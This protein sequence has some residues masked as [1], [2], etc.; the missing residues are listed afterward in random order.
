[1][2]NSE[3][4]K[5]SLFDIYHIEDKIHLWIKDEDGNARLFY[6]FYQ[7]I[8]YARGE[9]SVLKKLVHRFYQLDALAE[10]PVYTSKKLF[11]ENEK[12]EVLQLT[13]SRPSVLSRVS[14][15]L[16]ALYG[17]FD[18]YH[19]DI[20]VPTSYMVSKGLFPLCEL[21]LTYSEEKFGRRVRDVEVHNRIE[22]M[23]YSVP[24]LKTMY[25]SLSRSHR[26]DMKHNSIVL[27]CEDNFHEL[28]GKNPKELLQEIDRIFKTEDPDIVLSTFGDHTI[29]PYLFSQSQKLRI[30]PAFDRDKTAPI[31]RHVQTKGTSYNTYGTIVYR[32]PSYPLFGRWHIDSQNS[33]VHREADLLGIIELAR[34]SR[35]PIQK[36]SRASTGKALTSIE[37][38]VALRKGYLVPWQ[39]SAVESPKTALQLL[40]A[41]KGGLVFQPDISDGSVFEN[42]AQL[43]FAQMYPS[44]M[45][46]HNISPECVNCVC[47][48]KNRKAK[49]VPG[50]GYRICVRRRGIVSQALKHVLKRREYYKIGIK[51]RKETSKL[52]EYEQKQ[53]SLKWMLV[54][55]FGYLGYRNAKFG[56]L[57]SHESVNAFA[58]EKLLTAKECAE[59]RGYGFVHAITDSIF[60][61]KTDSSTFSREELNSLCEEIQSKTG[62]RIDVDGVYTWLLFPSSSQD[63]K[64]PVAN[65]YMGRFE[66]GKLKFRGIGSR[67][68][69]LPSIVKTAQNE[70]LEWMCGKVRV[71]ELKNSE[72]EILEIYNRYD[73]KLKKG[74]V[75]TEDLLV[76][77]S[78]SKTLEE[79]EVDGASSLSLLR[80]KELGI[81]VQA[82]EKIRYLVLNRK[83]KR[84]DRW[85]LPEEALQMMKKKER[86][87]A[88]PSVV[89][90]K[91]ETASEEIHWDRTYYR[92]LLV[93]SFREVWAPFASFSDFESLLDDQRWL[94]F[95]K[96]FTGALRS[97][98]GSGL[99]GI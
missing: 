99:A 87:S 89:P 40:E 42:V 9:E 48:E 8:V 73:L 27:R 35:L 47:C 58:R 31:R 83:G 3:I 74:T 7:P 96:E 82:G 88:K 86:T 50:L 92:K 43:D 49:I 33:F 20:E 55:S 17:K 2:N 84:K 41:D 81:D 94:P 19:S 72:T 46:N 14:R 67:R 22:D 4:V 60:I 59:E 64:M 80:L 66:N 45:V 39:K 23:E 93:A 62:I 52:G 57:E 21:K 97:Y 78:T 85:Y 54:T 63:H 1:M 69:D 30:F 90:K 32:A 37:V 51:E 76:R 10:I 56:R 75:E 36:M 24:K 98:Y 38:D 11:Y 44:I 95:G 70:M 61:R 5:G 28:S 91:S 71:E 12:V 68:K 25:M 26:I 53:N 79:Y 77:R 16:Y 15:K 6:D 34:L 29:F 65:R 13:I 18:I